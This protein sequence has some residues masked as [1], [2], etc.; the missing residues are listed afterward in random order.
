MSIRNGSRCSAWAGTGVLTVVLG[1]V[2]AVVCGWFCKR[3]LVTCLAVVCGA[4]LV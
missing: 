3:R 4:V 1:S 2:I